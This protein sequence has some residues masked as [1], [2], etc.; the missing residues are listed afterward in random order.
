M[1][2]FSSDVYLQ[3]AERLLEAIGDQDFFSGVVLGY[4]DEVCCRLRTTVVVHREPM[5]SVDMPRETTIRVI[6][7]WWEM[8]T[9][10]GDEELVNDFSFRE[11]MDLMSIDN[12]E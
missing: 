11:M 2:E 12:G 9:T 5:S 4:D 1:Y 10:I 7:V 8:S 3:V 6:P